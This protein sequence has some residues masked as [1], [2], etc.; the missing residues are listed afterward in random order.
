MIKLFMFNKKIC[1]VCGNVGTKALL[2][3][4]RDFE[5][6]CEYCRD[7]IFPLNFA[8]YSV[9]EYK[10]NKIFYGELCI[11]VEEKYKEKIEE[12]FSF[13]RFVKSDWGYYLNRA[14]AF[15][16][17]KFDKAKQFVIF[18]SKLVKPE[19]FKFIVYR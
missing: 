10:D 6:W 13:I 17:I 9:W 18:C 4:N 11:S 15:E 14:N 2:Y 19:I 16:K 1:K 3:I 12:N 5:G 8:Q 7:F